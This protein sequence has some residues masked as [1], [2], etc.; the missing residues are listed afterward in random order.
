MAKKVVLCL[1][2]VLMLG[3][4]QMATPAFAGGRLYCGLT[5]YENYCVGKLTEGYE[6]FIELVDDCRGC[7][8]VVDVKPIVWAELELTN[9]A[10]HWQDSG[11]VSTERTYQLTSEGPW[12]LVDYEGEVNYIVSPHSDH[13]LECMDGS[14]G[15]GRNDPEGE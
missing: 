8:P 14:G 13:S 5:Q 11:Y 6:V 2:V 12:L 10:E 9:F 1:M 7:Q 15:R 3:M 4:V